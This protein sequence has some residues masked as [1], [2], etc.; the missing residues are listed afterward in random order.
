MTGKDINKAIQDYA[1]TKGA[2]LIDVRSRAEYEDGHIPDSQNVPLKK[3]ENIVDVTGDREAPLFVY[4]YS[5]TRSK[6]AATAL[7]KMGYTD[8]RNIGGMAEY[9]GRLIA[10]DAD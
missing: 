10:K 8:V 3:I 7:K 1:D 6:Q 2:F 4:C 9:T 5:G